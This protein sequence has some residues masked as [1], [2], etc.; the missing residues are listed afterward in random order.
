MH[1]TSLHKTAIGD[2]LGADGS[3]VILV[4][5]FCMKIESG[6]LSKRDLF[7]GVVITSIGSS[8]VPK[9]KCTMMGYMHVYA[10]M[11]HAV[12]LAGWLHLTYVYIII[13]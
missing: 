11:V 4:F 13:M 7:G 8:I 5:K 12:R 6:S 10:C 1:P 9:I 2:A 3:A